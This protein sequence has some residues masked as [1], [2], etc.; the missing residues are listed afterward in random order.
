M[1]LRAHVQSI[2]MQRSNKKGSKRPRW[3]NHELLYWLSAKRNCTESKKVNQLSEKQ[4]VGEYYKRR[5]KSR[6]TKA[7][8]K[9]QVERYSEEQ[10]Y[11]CISCKRR[12]RKLLV[13]DWMN[14]EE[15]L[16]DGAFRDGWSDECFSF[17]SSLLKTATANAV[18]REVSTQAKRGTRL[19][20]KP[21]HKVNIKPDGFDSTCYFVLI[22]N[23]S[24]YLWRR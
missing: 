7:Q 1:L 24:N 6:K 17:L 8:S 21:L 19:L 23:I 5:G 13:H 10:L 2:P 12:P 15:G 22:E 3:L 20:M 9:G 14:A 4:S 18:I 16:T 11:S